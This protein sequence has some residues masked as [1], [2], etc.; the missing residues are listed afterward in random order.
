MVDEGPLNLLE[1]SIG[2]SECVEQAIQLVIDCSIA[3]SP[4]LIGKIVKC[5][6][7]GQYVRRS[8][9][10]LMDETIVLLVCRA[11]DQFPPQ[12]IQKVMAE[13]SE[14][15]LLSNS[16]YKSHAITLLSLLA[17]KDI[18]VLESFPIKALESSLSFSDIECVNLCLSVIE[19][20]QKHNGFDY[21]SELTS[22]LLSCLRQSEE[23][24]TIDRILKLLP[25]N[26]ELIDVVVYRLQIVSPLHI[27]FI[28][29][30]FI[31][32]HVPFQSLNEKQIDIVLFFA[33][34]NANLHLAKYLM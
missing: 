12:I 7:S 29:Y 28:V 3:E 10:E 18:S 6:L 8:V 23:K 24:I 26:K 4:D 2:N 1:K 22:G 13:F 14:T 9:A 15:I 5:V 11:K 34:K 31:S 21:I 16:P 33:L 20:L 27:R 19:S 32:E 30:D 25:V 17:E